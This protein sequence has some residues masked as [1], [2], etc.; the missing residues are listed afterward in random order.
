MMSEVQD[1]CGRNGVNVRLRVILQPLKDSLRTSTMIRVARE[2]SITALQ[3]ED[4]FTMNLNRN[5]LDV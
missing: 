2:V 1:D 5:F 4:T 3:S